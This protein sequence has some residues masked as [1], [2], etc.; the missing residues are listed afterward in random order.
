MT[1][2][3]KAARPASDDARPVERRTLHF[4]L[5]QVDPTQP[6][7]LNVGLQ[8]FPIRS[9]DNATRDKARG[10]HGFLR[11]VPDEDITH[12]LTVALPRDA[13]VLMEVTRP[14]EI[15]GVMAEHTILLGVHVPRAGHVAAARRIMKNGGLRWDV[16]P[17]LAP[18]R[19][20]LAAADD[21]KPDL[22]DKIV[23]WQTATDA[24]A[25]LLYHHPELLNLSTDKGGEVPAYILQH[26][27]YHALN[28]TGE[29][30]EGD[31]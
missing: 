7:T 23:D 18:Y 19:A 17:K 25:A 13:I 14:V 3:T 5:P 21:I 26:C 6:L 28:R 10:T 31:L 11:Y 22:P 15:E 1:K 30:T 9:H 20:A 4:S 27:I 29:L 16:H 24:G 2:S 12:H 8:S